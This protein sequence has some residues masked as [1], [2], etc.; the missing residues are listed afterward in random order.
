MRSHPR[1]LLLSHPDIQQHRFCNLFSN[2]PRSKKYKTNTKEIQIQIHPAAL[3]QQLVFLRC[4][5]IQSTFYFLSLQPRS[6]GS[7]KSGRLY[8]EVYPGDNFLLP[9]LHFLAADL[10]K[11]SCHRLAPARRKVDFSRDRRSICRCQGLSGS[12]RR[13]LR[14]MWRPPSASSL[15][16]VELIG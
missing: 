12:A 8:I 1:R 2:F 13:S 10:T 16:S 11:S 4:K 15:R 7:L 6:P 5:K 9:P 3:L 14:L